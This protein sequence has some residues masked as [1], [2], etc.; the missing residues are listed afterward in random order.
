[1][2]AMNTAGID[3]CSGQL[4]RTAESEL[5]IEIAEELKKT[6]AELYFARREMPN[7]RVETRFHLSFS[8][9][10]I[11]IAIPGR[12]VTFEEGTAEA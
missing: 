6:A 2:T 10:D 8:Q 9:C 3:R 7:T 4:S 11:F 1:M 5:I 12:G